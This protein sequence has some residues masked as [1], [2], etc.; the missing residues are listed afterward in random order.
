MCYAQDGKNPGPG[1]AGEEP[2]ERRLP[3]QNQLGVSEGFANTS[4]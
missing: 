3:E 4:N 2:W 1:D